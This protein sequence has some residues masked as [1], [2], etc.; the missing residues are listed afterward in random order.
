MNLNVDTQTNLIQI[1]MC[2]DKYQITFLVIFICTFLL[3]ISLD[4]ICI[5]KL[6]SSKLFSLSVL[7]VD[8]KST[9]VEHIFSFGANST[10]PFNF[11]HSALIP[12]LAK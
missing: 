11:I 5:T 2:L 4:V 7:P 1:Y 6:D 8:T 3:I 9:I 12:F 10:A